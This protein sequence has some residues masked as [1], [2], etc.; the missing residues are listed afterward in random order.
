MA[1]QKH[2]DKV[3]NN[4]LIETFERHKHLGKISSEL[5]LPHITV[6]RRLQSLGLK[7]EKIGS[8]KKIDL[9]EIIEG[10]H[11]YYQTYKLR[12]RLIKEKIVAYEC[13]VCK[14]F[15]WNGNPL[16]LQLDHIDGD[17]SNH[18]LENL[19]LICP[20]CHSQTD[21]WCGKNKTGR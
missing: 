4:S 12:N 1:K 16:S 8:G 7:T 15:E 11:P 10:Q 19:R 2:T 20:N 5:G 6:W 14:T 13:S 18:L 3:D 21:T 17:S 9:S